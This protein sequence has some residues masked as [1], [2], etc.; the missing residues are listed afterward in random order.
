VR[1]FGSSAALARGAATEAS[2][3]PQKRKTIKPAMRTSPGRFDGVFVQSDQ[4]PGGLRACALRSSAC[5]ARKPGHR[6][7]GVELERSVQPPPRFL[8]LSRR[9]GGRTWPMRYDKRGGAQLRPTPSEARAR[10]MRT[11]KRSRAMCQWR[12]RAP[13]WCPAGSTSVARRTG[14][15]VSTQDWRSRCGERQP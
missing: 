12:T 8:Q 9:I 6:Q 5:L 7:L 14:S 1:I 13:A 11:L 10:S 15:H 4:P 3:N 2:N